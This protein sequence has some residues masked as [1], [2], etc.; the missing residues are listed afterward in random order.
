MTSNFRLVVVPIVNDLFFFVFFYCIFYVN[1]ATIKLFS[2]ERGY[3]I[4]I[5]LRLFFITIFL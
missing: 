5:L 1:N 3:S 2:P 4:T